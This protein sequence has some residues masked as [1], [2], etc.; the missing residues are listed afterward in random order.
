LNKSCFVPVFTE[1]TNGGTKDVTELLD[2]SSGYIQRGLDM[3]PKQG[4]LHPWRLSQNV[5]EGYKTA[6]W[7]DRVDES[8]IFC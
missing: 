3:F 2:F 8:I 6:L 1:T 5:I 4:S 7:S